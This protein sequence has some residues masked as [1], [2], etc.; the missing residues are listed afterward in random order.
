MSPLALPVQGIRCIRAPC[1]TAV[2]SFTFR[3]TIVVTGTVYPPSP[4]PIVTPYRSEKYIGTAYLNQTVAVRVGQLVILDL[5]FLTSQQ[6]VQLLFDS[7]MLRLL[8]G[9]SLNYLPPGGWRFVVAQPGTSSLIVQGKTCLDSGIDCGLV[10]L[11][12][13]MLTTTP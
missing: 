10:V 8:P 4:P 1:P 7:R 13:V 11:F 3:V 6:S 9:Q 2:R 12:Q 5:P